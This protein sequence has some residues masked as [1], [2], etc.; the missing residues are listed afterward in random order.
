M[1]IN[2]MIKE[3]KQKTRR[4]I[5]KNIKNI[6]CITLTISASYTYRID[7][8]IQEVID[9]YFDNLKSRTGRDFEA[10]RFQTYVAAIDNIAKTMKACYPFIDLDGIDMNWTIKDIVEL[11]ATEYFSLPAKTITQLKDEGKIK[12]KRKK[13]GDV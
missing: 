8:T 7:M 4:D 9:K 12:Q 1:D 5:T 2:E 6:I 3:T 13:K 11:I 10:R